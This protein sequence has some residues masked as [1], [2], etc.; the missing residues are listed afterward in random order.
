[1]AEET[2]PSD[3]A[4]PGRFTSNSPKYRNGGR[5]RLGD[6]ELTLLGD[7]QA[8]AIQALIEALQAERTYV[9]GEGASARLETAPDHGERIRAANSLLDRWGGKP[10]Q[11]ITGDDGGPIEIANV[12]LTTLSDAQFAAL[13]ALR[14]SLKAGK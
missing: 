13:V 4:I 12:D 6:G 5:R 9:I 1:V 8:P 7:A 3:K 14:D 2:K 11:A 10:A